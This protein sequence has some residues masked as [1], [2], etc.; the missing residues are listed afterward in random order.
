MKRPPK[1]DDTLEV[2]LPQ[3]T[4]QAF[5]E[6]CKAEGSTASDTV[7]GFIE[8]HLAKPLSAKEPAFYRPA[9]SFAAIAAFA[10]VGIALFTPTPSR[11]APDLK[12]MFQEMD[13]NKDG[14][15]SETEFAARRPMMARRD[16][17]GP[18]QAGFGGPPPRADVIFIAGPPPGAPMGPPPGPPPGMQ[19]LSDKDRE[20]FRAKMFGETD[21]NKDGAVSFEEF[22]SH[23]RAQLEE[24]F[25]TLDANKD[26]KVTQ[27]EMTAALEAGPTPGAAPVRF[28]FRGPPGDDMFARLDKNKDGAISDKEFADMQ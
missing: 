8:G 1:K 2:R 21:A 11:A 13:T 9:A 16:G 26:G 18:G 25:K 4:K 3:E 14:K 15:V 7:R 6:R 27:V 24:S 17:A 20:A 23:R 10:A 12:S 22:V 19:P 5:M 28:A